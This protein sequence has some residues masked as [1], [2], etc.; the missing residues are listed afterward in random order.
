MERYYESLKSFGTADELANSRKIIDEFRNGIGKHLHDVLEK[1]A[2]THK[3]WVSFF[4][5]Y[6]I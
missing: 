3:N 1:R 4:I 2:K 5:R 6:F